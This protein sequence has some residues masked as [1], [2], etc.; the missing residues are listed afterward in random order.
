MFLRDQH[1]K[2]L[3][4]V[5]GIMGY[6]RKVEV[7]T[8]RTFHALVPYV[9]QTVYVDGSCG[10]DGTEEWLM[11]EFPD[12]PIA[13]VH[14]AWSDD[15]P[16][17]RNQYINFGAN[18]FSTDEYDLWFVVSD[19]DE[20]FSDP[21]GKNLR[22]MIESVRRDN[23]MLQVS[24]KSVTIG[25]D[26]SRVWE[27]IDDFHKP[28]VFRY[29]PGMEYWGDRSEVTKGKTALHEALV[30]DGRF[31]WRPRNINDQDGRFVYEHVKTREVVWERGFRNFIVLGGG[32]N[33]GE[34][35]PLWKP[36]LHMMSDILEREVGE[37]GYNDVLDY[38]REGNIDKRLYDY[39]GSSEI[40]EGFY[41]YF[42]YYHPE[43]MPEDLKEEY[44]HMMKPT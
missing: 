41:T 27:N 11:N 36:F 21:L 38:M 37:F 8:L 31:V 14:K 42:I 7:E 13:V 40:R 44:Q 10:E 6:R 1:K 24:C 9:D 25:D 2:P 4:I 17:Q 20:V 43:E 28:L 39:D 29:Y 15:F 19:T 34:K 33:L 23:D 32:P 35:Q 26:G 3:K 16:G 22:S 5:Y 12:K 30:C 18:T